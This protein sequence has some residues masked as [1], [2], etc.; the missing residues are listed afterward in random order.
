MTERMEVAPAPEFRSDDVYGRWMME[1][2]Q[3]LDALGGE[4]TAMGVLYCGMEPAV[5][6]TSRVADFATHIADTALPWILVVDGLTGTVRDRISP[7]LGGNILDF[8]K[9]TVIG[10]LELGAFPVAA[11]DRPVSRLV[12]AG[13]V[14][15][16]KGVEAMVHASQATGE[17]VRG[18]VRRANV[19]RT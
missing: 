10:F 13:S 4:E 16:G 1:Y 14:A 9:G 5:R 6:F 8:P 12:A 2:R 19:A 17:R 15:L 7:K 3:V 18:I 11:R